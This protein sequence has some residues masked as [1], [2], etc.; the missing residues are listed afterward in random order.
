MR[1][2]FSIFLFAVFSLAFVAQAHG[3]RAVGAERCGSCHTFAYEKWLKGPHSKAHLSLVGEELTSVKCQICHIPGKL[4]DTSTLF[5]GVQC[6]S[7]HGNGQYYAHDYVMRD[8]ELSRKVGMVDPGPTTC[9]S[10]HTVDVPSLKTFSF[11]EYW[12]MIA[13]GRD[14]RLAWEARLSKLK[15]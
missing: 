2:L 1:N 5:V 7:C 10:C 12:K 4:K 11:E 8:K 14:E 13:H 15:K 3:Q 6:E 9:T